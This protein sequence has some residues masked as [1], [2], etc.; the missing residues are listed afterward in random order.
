MEVEAHACS[1]FRLFYSKPETCSPQTLK[2]SSTIN[3]IFWGIS[4]FQKSSVEKSQLYC[5]SENGIIFISLSPKR[6]AIAQQALNHLST[7]TLISNQTSRA[8]W[9]NFPALSCHLPSTMSPEFEWT[10][11]NTMQNPAGIDRFLLVSAQSCAR[12]PSNDFHPMLQEGL[13]FVENF[14]KYYLLLLQHVLPWACILFL[15]NNN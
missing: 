5:S 3:V 10:Q 13:K 12:S 4:I 6:W 11:K 9:S 1:G 15:H 2:L 7:R 8:H 14:G